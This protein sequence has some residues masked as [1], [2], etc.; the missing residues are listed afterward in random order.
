[1][2]GGIFMSIKNYDELRKKIEFRNKLIDLGYCPVVGPTGP[3]GPI[4][5]S[6]TEGMFLR[7]F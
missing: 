6:S 5:S 1:M 2:V 3:T 7:L 4:A